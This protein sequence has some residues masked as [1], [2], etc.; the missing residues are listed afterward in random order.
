[1]IS[2][3]EE[4]VKGLCPVRPADGHKGTFGTALILAGSRYMPGAQMLCTSSALRSGVGIVKVL[5]PEESLVSTKANCPCAVLCEYPDTVAGA[6]RRYSAESSKASSVA[7]GPGIDTDDGRIRA[8]L[9]Y[10][11]D[12]TPYLV[13]DA[14]ALDII[15]KDTLFWQ[16]LFE[17]RK[18][19]G[20]PYPVITPH[21]GE[22]ERLTREGKDGFTPERCVQ[23]ARD[24]GCVLVLKKHKTL[25]AIPGGEWYINNTGNNGMGKGGSGDVLTGLAAGFLAQGLAPADAAVAAVYLHGLSGDIAAEKTGERAMLPTD[26]IDCLASSYRKTG[27]T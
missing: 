26:L 24:W 15:S 3:T 4:M 9:Q 7:I 20:L 6:L 21:P 13:I 27:W 8:I 17:A 12:N 14:G 5:A 19:K 25:I 11:V 2:I 23:F 1:M 10:A 18:G 16:G 22:F